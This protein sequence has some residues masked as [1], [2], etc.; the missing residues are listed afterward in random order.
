MAGCFILGT[1]GQFGQILTIREIMA[2]LN[3]SELL[4]GISFGAWMLW[5]AIGSAMAAKRRNGFSQWR[6][7]WLPLA[8]IAPTAQLI[9]IRL[10]TAPAGDLPGAAL[11]FGRAIAYTV[12]GSLPLAMLVGFLI[13]NLLRRNQVSFAELYAAE[14]AGAAVGGLLTM[15]CLTWFKSPL[16]LSLVTGFIFYPAVATTVSLPG[17]RP[18]TIGLAALILL[19][20]ASHIDRRSEQWRWRRVFQDA[21]VLSALETR[22]GRVVKVK[23]SKD[24]PTRVLRNGEDVGPEGFERP[25]LEESGIVDLMALQHPAPEFA[26]IIGGA[27]THFPK[28]LSHHGLE[29]IDICEPDTAIRAIAIKANR[30][31]TAGSVLRWVTFDARTYIQSTHRKYDLVIL[32]SSGGGTLMENRLLTREFFKEVSS[33]LSSDGVFCVLLPAFGAEPLYTGPLQAK[34]TAAI[35]S[36]MSSV[37]ANS[38]PVP[39]MGHLLLAMK[40]NR[41]THL[42]FNPKFL[43]KRILQRM[44]QHPG[45]QLPIDDFKKTGDHRI[46]T[47]YF[48]SLWS[49]VLKSAKNVFTGIEQ[50]PAVSGFHASLASSEVQMNMDARPSAIHYALAAGSESKGDSS[51][52][53]LISIV[54]WPVLMLSL[55]SGVHYRCGF[56][57][58]KNA[59]D[60]SSKSHF[61]CLFTAAVTG[62]HG[63]CLLIALILIFQNTYGC[64]YL[65]IGLLS[66]LYMAGMSLGSVTAGRDGHRPE[67]RLPALLVV[68]IAL[69]ALSVGLVYASQPGLWNRM[70]VLTVIFAV[71]GANGALFP[72]LQ[73]IAAKNIP[74]ADSGLQLYIFD[75]IGAAS[76]AWIAGA[77]LIP[78][79]GIDRTIMG[80]SLLVFLTWIV[81]YYGIDS[82]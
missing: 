42:E 6:A 82:H 31:P 44:Q 73:K 52:N 19:A 81:D 69:S 40:H 10:L 18:V 66:A 39:A 8:T 24:T 41:P 43:A 77:W 64:L 27:L 76:A 74:T 57:S 72:Y 32:L 16:M 49:G 67:R 15:W 22:F 14:A 56:F 48:D 25:T 37:F 36:A 34:R 17:N 23:H 51:E 9:L 58:L 61:T 30:F 79:I 5:S 54:L 11:P 80:S 29:R 2:G 45:L 20:A 60:F 38:Q 13:G 55:L 68:M 12:I 28:R 50:Q 3:G 7:Y 70:I 62:F 53:L 71:G 35:Y 59:S 21:Q 1:Y 63:M 65:Q 4:I 26:F 33:I 47:L 78:L 75:L 46:A